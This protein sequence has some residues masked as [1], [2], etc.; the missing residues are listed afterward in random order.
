VSAQNYANHVHRPTVWLT[1]W[2][3]AAIAVAVSIWLMVFQPSLQSLL[4]LVLAVTVALMVTV[5]RVSALRLQD[6]IIR[7]EMQV[8]LERLGCAADAARL[9]LPQL[10]ALR[11][12]SD[13]EIPG[14][15][16]RAHAERLSPDQIKR[17]IR[18]WQADYH[19]T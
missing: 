19:R 3:G 17:A 4:L 11:F 12:A 7:L 1:A 15:I 14:L 6:R 16:E 18:D 2:L 13:A 8:R 9:S 5:M 10:V